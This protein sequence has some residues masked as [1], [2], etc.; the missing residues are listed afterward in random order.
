LMTLLSPLLFREWNARVERAAASFEPDI[1]IAFKGPF[2]TRSTLRLLR[3][4]GIRLY[5]Y[6]PDLMVFAVGTPLED[7]LP[8]YDCV[9]DTKRVGDPLTAQRIP[10]RSRVF[11]PHGYDPDV[12]VP[13]KVDVDDERRYG[14]DASF[15]GTWSPLKEETLLKLVTL[16][17]SLDLRIRGNS[18]ERCRSRTLGRFVRGP[19]FKGTAYVRAIAATRINL[20]LLGVTRE[21]RDETTTRTYEIPACRAFMLHERTRE[22]GELFE[23]DKEVATFGDTREL[24]EQLDYYLSHP[25]ERHALAAAGYRRAVPAYSYDRRMAALLAWH[26]DHA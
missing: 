3:R 21:A 1:L 11:L 5:N 2:L 16:R 17:P 23:V 9:F 18:W 25:E 12:H 19:A 15:V 10:L 7:A 4:R 14:C 8:E 13:L 20:G 6:Y 22:L 26:A 24:A